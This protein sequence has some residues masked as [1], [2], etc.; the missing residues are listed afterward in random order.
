MYPMCI[1][2]GAIR[3]ILV[4]SGGTDADRQLEADEKPVL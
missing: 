4:L 1:P 3:W 2:H